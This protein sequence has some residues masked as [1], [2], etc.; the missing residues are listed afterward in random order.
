MNRG[1]RVGLV[2]FACTA[3]VVAIVVGT[4]LRVETKE[5]LNVQDCTAFAWPEIDANCL[6]GGNRHFA[7]RRVASRIGTRWRSSDAQALS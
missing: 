3:T 2:V 4:T 7:S 1:L 5:A 6:D